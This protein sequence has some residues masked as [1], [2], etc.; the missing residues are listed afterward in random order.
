MKFNVVVLGGGPGGYEAAIRCAQYGLN[1]ALIEARDLG[2]TCLNRGCIPTKALLHGAEVVGTVKN[3]AVYGIKTGEVSLD[4][5]K[6]SAHKD[7]VV[8]KLRG[9]IAALEKAHGVSVIEG[10]GVLKQSGLIVVNGKEISADKIIL[11]TGSAPMRPPISGSDSP[12]VL[13]SDEVLTS[14]TCPESLVI[15]GGGVIG[16]EFASL[17]AALGKKVTVLEM[18]PS[19]LP[20]VDGETS[21]RLIQ[22]LQR[23]KGEVVTGAK[24]PAINDGQQVNGD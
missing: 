23:K 21:A 2:G 13:T 17:F 12:K 6:L 24:V 15:I 19:I 18:L 9:G 20:G 16:L 4:F 14:S 7:S 10:F 1:T 22:L 3:S 11:A 5:A 8:S